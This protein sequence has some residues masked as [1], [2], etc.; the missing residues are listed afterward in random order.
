MTNH[1]PTLAFILILATLAP[2]GNFYF[3]PSDP[4]PLQFYLI[5]EWIMGLVIWALIK[6]FATGD[7]DF[8]FGRKEDGKD[9][10]A[11]I[12]YLRGKVDDRGD[13]FLD[14]G[15]RSRQCAKEVVKNN[16]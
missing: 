6:R 16:E 12:N 1:L 14:K 5:G 8:V 9:W 3:Y 2:Y 15:F 7:E 13:P 4:V 11:L 10:P